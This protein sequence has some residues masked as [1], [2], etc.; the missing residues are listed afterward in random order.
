M[1]RLPWKLRSSYHAPEVSTRLTWSPHSCPPVCICGRPREQ[2]PDSRRYRKLA[3]DTRRPVWKTKHQNR[4]VGHAR[5]EPGP[6]GEGLRRFPRTNT[7]NMHGFDAVWRNPNDRPDQTL[8]AQRL[9]DRRN[10]AS[11]EVVLE[12]TVWEADHKRVRGQEIPPSVTEVPVS[13]RR[14]PATSSSPSRC[15]GRSRTGTPASIRRPYARSPGLWVRGAT[16]SRRAAH[17]TP[18]GWAPRRYPGPE[19]HR[20]LAP[21]SGGCALS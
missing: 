6:A 11:S 15:P 18:L 3:A 12:V 2:N 21:S 1:P 5:T 13:L 17:R 16:C 20:Y 4:R 9:A 19:E 10:G 14:K 7:L 8:S